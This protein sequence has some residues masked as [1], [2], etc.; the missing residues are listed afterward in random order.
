VAGSG[1]ACTLLMEEGGGKVLAKV[2]A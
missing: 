1:R 2:G